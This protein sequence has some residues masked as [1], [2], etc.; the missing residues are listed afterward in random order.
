MVGVAGKYKGCNTCRARRV[1]CDQTRPFCKKCTDYGRECGGY[2][3]D[4]VFI[5]GTQDERGRVGSHPPRNAH[6]P[7][8]PHSRA[9][10]PRIDRLNIQP[11]DIKPAWDEMVSL[12]AETGPRT[13]RLV[14]KHTN[15]ESSIPPASPSSI[16]DGS[17][18]SLL[19]VSQTLDITPTFQQEAFR[20]KCKC[21]I[22]IPEASSGGQEDGICLFLYQQSSSAGYS[23]EHGWEGYSATVDTVREMGPA[24]FQAF[25]AH[26]FFA[27][28]YRPSAVLA[29]LLNRQPTFLCN[30]EWTV[31]PWES[32]PRTPL[33]ELLDIMVMLPSLFSQADSVVEGDGSV[34]ARSMAAELLTNSMNIER[35]FDIWYSVV[36]S[37]GPFWADETASGYG[38]C[39][40]PLAFGSALLCLVHI[41][42]WAALVAFY[43]CICDLVE[44]S[45]DPRGEGSSSSTS[46]DFDGRKYQPAHTKTLATMVCRSLDFALNTTT[47]LDLLDT[48]VSIIQTFYESL[49]GCETEIQWLLEFKERLE[50]RKREM[51]RWLQEK[52]WV[53]MERFE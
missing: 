16:G 41:F 8:S 26:H 30:P 39:S 36:F 18:L 51:S 12:N 34:E 5:V 33:D 38:S 35:Q 49:Q 7:R 27:R 4:M 25:P 20:V 3:R 43:G 53:Q 23:S 1:K 40:V 42:Y 45:Q 15:L 9:S 28:V 21:L 14:A 32:Q 46:P 48:P 10:T 50:V 29:A 13:F 22:H 24:A 44:A 17:S 11:A 52:K 19:D 37:N 31:V 2:G 47:Q 6:S